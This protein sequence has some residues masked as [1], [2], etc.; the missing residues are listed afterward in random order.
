V[1]LPEGALGI[2][3]T[4]AGLADDSG[5][6]L[7]EMMVVLV[8]LGILVL[9][10][11][12]T[13]L[14]VKASAV[15]TAVQADLHNGL[16]ASEAVYTA[17]QNFPTKA[18]TPGAD[19][20]QGNPKSLQSLLHAKDPTL[21]YLPSIKSLAPWAGSNVL[22]AEPFD[23]STAV[24]A[25]EDQSEGCWGVADNEGPALPTSGIPAGVSYAWY[26]AGSSATTQCD[27]ANMVSKG[28][29]GS[30]WKT[31]SSAYAKEP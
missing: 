9:I 6:T 23:A 28:K 31:T 13:F 4:A 25:A 8:I 12:P 30:L 16:I 19:A 18:T 5:F 11:V 27:A 24:Y 17:S 22:S 1:G 20:G 10:A 7:I 26:R 2:G 15:G 21:T 3:G 29:A 14:G